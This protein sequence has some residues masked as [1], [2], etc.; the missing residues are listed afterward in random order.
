ML[1]IDNLQ[2]EVASL[3]DKIYEIEELRHSPSLRAAHASRLDS[4][5]S[6]VHE[7]IINLSP[8]VAAFETNASDAPDIT[9]PLHKDWAKVTAQH[10]QLE[11]EMQEDPW[12]VR[13]RT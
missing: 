12:L 8:R 13:F 1:E 7:T 4:L 10:A 2:V 11:Q 3:L 6:E 9:T 5:L